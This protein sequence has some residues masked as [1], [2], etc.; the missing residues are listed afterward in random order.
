MSKGLTGPREKSSLPVVL[1][2]V[3]PGIPR[4]IAPR[5][6]IEQIRNTAPFLFEEGGGIPPGL[7]YVDFI[8]GVAA[9]PDR[10]LSHL[11]YFRLCVSAHWATVATFVP[12]DVDN[13][14]R[15]KLWH[16]ALPAEVV[17]AMAR[18]ALEARGWDARPV[19]TRWVQGVSGHN[20]EWFSIAVAAYAATRRRDPELAAEIAGA[21]VAECQMEAELFA[22]LRAKGEGLDLLRLSTLIAHNLGDL[23]RVIEMWNLAPA[24][25]PHPDPL[26]EA[27]FK[28]G[29]AEGA[30]GWRAELARAGALNQKYMADENHRH[31]PLRKPKSLRRSV[32]LLL[33]VGPFFDDWGVRVAKHPALSREDIAEIALCLIEGWERLPK[34]VGYPRALA[35]ILEGF[36]GGLN[37]LSRYLPA[38][39]ARQLQAGEL[40][41]LI[42]V[43]RSRFEANWRGL[44]AKAH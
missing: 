27:V 10:E 30:T 1:P 18:L 26:R 11:E 38:K 35:G 37:E 24:E 42:A 20:G 7:P 17:S 22:R 39:R 41:A 36:R 33:P 29:H 19:T 31:F 34:A 13:Q 15:H 3:L 9:D 6:L 44:A 14:I 16:P 23:D 8:R 21:I 5:T 40:R 2:E 12:T 28:L 43:P 25:S 32:E 4:G